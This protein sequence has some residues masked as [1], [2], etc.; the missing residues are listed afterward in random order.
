MVS[1][2][3][4]D[5]VRDTNPE[6]LVFLRLVNLTSIPRKVMECLNLEV[7]SKHVENKKVI[8]SSQHR[9]IRDKSCFANL[10]Q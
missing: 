10:L 9:F 3:E 6:I 4:I 1:C 2:G 5:P 7:T 8:R